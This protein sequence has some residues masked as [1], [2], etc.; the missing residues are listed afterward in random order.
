MTKRE[1]LDDEKTSTPTDD[2][3]KHPRDMR[4]DERRD[5]MSALARK[6]WEKARAAQASGGE[7]LAQ[8]PAD[9]GTGAGIDEDRVALVR[10][11]IPVGEIMRKLKHEAKQG[12]TAAARELRAWLSQFPPD[13]SAADASDLAAPQRGRIAALLARLIAEDERALQ[14]EE[15]DGGTEDGSDH[16]GDS[17]RLLDSD[18]VDTTP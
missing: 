7:D 10:V 3:K 18:G 11:P 6:R 17:V 9:D 4:A 12:D 8:Q 13:D 2:A 5:A 14:A 16:F 1:S 15:L